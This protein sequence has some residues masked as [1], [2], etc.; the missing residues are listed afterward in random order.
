MT[1]KN[2]KH[3]TFYNKIDEDNGHRVSDATHIT[4]S[5]AGTVH[6]GTYLLFGNVHIHVGKRRAYGRR[7]GRFIPTPRKYRT[8]TEDRRPGMGAFN[9]L[10][11]HQEDMNGV[12]DSLTTDFAMEWIAGFKREQPNE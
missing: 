9:I 10:E 2:T 4:V 11:R 5:D 12:E 7:S 3:R 8:K 6:V 1:R